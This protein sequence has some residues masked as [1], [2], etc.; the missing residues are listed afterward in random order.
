MQRDGDVVLVGQPEA[1]VDHVGI[2]AGVL[3]DLKA[4]SARLDALQHRR[5]MSGATETLKAE[6]DRH[7][8]EGFEGPVDLEIAVLAEAASDQGGQAAGDGDR[9]QLWRS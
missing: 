4:T 7:V 6:V 2:C 5:G 9:Y 1:S 8:L 3:V